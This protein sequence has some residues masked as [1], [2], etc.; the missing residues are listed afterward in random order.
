DSGRR[1]VTK[2]WNAG[3]FAATHLADYT[4]PGEP[5]ALAPS[6]EWLLAR[7]DATITRATAALEGYEFAAARAEV[8]R[9]FWSDLCDNYFELAKAR[10]Y[11]DDPAPRLAARWTLAHALLAVLKLFAPFL[12]YVTEALYLGLFR[13]REASASVHTAPWPAALARATAPR[14]A[15]GTALLAV[16]SQARKA[17]AERGLSVGAEVAALTIQAP[18]GTLAP[19]RAAEADLRSATRARAV[20]IVAGPAASAAL[21]TLAFDADAPAHAAEG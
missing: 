13:A 11:G 18:R 17:K 9:F 14:P 20:R 5:P 12:P 15:F 10:L 8:E 7:L 21:V 19:L 3:R 2:L 4:P 6:D 16:L 1:L